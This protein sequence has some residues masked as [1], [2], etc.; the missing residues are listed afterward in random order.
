MCE[1]RCLVA[2]AGADFENTIVGLKLQQLEV[3]GL[4]RRLRSGLTKADRQGR[5]FVGAV[6]HGFGKEKVSRR[7]VE[8]AQYL[9]L[10]NSL[11]PNCFDEL[12]PLPL[13]PPVVQTVSCQPSILSSSL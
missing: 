9:Q 12:M 3:K 1:Q 13:V 8:G 7:Q 5:I 4:Q 6:L 10:F 11:I 2:A